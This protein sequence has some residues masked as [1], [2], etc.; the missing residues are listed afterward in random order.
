MAG[1]GGGFLA[2][3]FYGRWLARSL[4]EL[5]NQRVTPVVRLELSEQVSVNV[6]C[7]VEDTENIDGSAVL[8]D[9]GDSIVAVEQD[10]Y[11]AVGS[12]PVSMD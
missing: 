1:R 10:S 12:L 4:I 2:C 8:D 11:V 9:V 6:E 7:A 5:N 3:Q